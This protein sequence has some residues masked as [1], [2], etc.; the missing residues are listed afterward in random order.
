MAVI[1]TRKGSELPGKPDFKLQ[2][3][4]RC[5]FSPL[6]V[7][8][9]KSMSTVHSNYWTGMCWHLIYV[10]GSLKIPNLVKISTHVKWLQKCT[11]S[12]AMRLNF[13]CKT[14]NLNFQNTTPLKSGLNL[15][16]LM[17]AQ[18]NWYN[19]ATESGTKS[20]IKLSFVENL[21]AFIQ[22]LINVVTGSTLFIKVSD[23]KIVKN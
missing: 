2:Q 4:E 14:W 7:T 22:N 9:M 17:P 16:I 10:W 19:H 1:W 11:S 21:N 15:K 18:G 6:L 20:K 12:H 13:H 5:H 8:H 3:L 23:I